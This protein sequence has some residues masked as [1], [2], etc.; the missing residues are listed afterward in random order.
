M[1]LAPLPRLRAHV[2]ELL[3]L[4]I[5]AAHFAATSAP[6]ATVSWI[7]DS[8]DSWNYAPNWSSNPSLP[9]PGDDVLI[10]QPGFD[11]IT[12]DSFSGPQAINSL[13]CD[14]VLQITSA[15]ELSLAADSQVNGT[16]ALTDGTLSGAGNVTIAGTFAWNGTLAAGGKTTLTSAS[17]TTIGNL[18]TA[19]LS[20]ILENSGIV[21]LTPS[22]S[23]QLKLVDG[24]F[25]NLAGGT[26][27]YSDGTGSQTA[28]VIASQGASA[29]NNAGTFNFSAFR[30]SVP[31]TRTVAAPFNN[32]GLTNIYAGTLTLSG[33]GSNS[34][35]IN[36]YPEGN[37]F[38]TTALFTNS[39][40]VNFNATNT[41]ATL[42]T[43]FFTNGATGH[44]NLLSGTLSLTG[45]G[46]NFGNFNVAQNATLT[47]SSTT[48]AIAQAGSS[49]TGA[50]NVTLNTISNFSGTLN[51][52][53]SVTIAGA[54]SFLTD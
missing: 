10:S 41:G 40:V 42:D 38:L 18:S 28:L 27:N 31:Q 48:G 43:S 15:A 20:R 4:L 13:V 45:P 3:F 33:G 22:G 46:A 19:I 30:N 34:G 29:F 47:I 39:G 9:G 35:T 49:I 5:L 37:L 26:F 6:A 32:S 2:A 16:L 8:N 53:G 24:T 50:G 12:L 14:E 7:V 25:N 44:L 1:L 17:T 23:G 36:V 54:V 21:N 51:V 11:T 52:T